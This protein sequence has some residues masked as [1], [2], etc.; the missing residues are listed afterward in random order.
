MPAGEFRVLMWF[1]TDKES[2]R[3]HLAAVL[4]VTLNATHPA[5]RINERTD[6]EFSC[7]INKT[8]VHGRRE[9]KVTILLRWVI[10]SEEPCTQCEN[11]G[12][13]KDC[14]RKPQLLIPLHG[15]ASG[16]AGR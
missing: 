7:G 9:R 14:H 16:C 10:R 11:V 2:K 15:Q 3:P 12:Q 13:R 8:K 1:L 6:V 5:I 4:L